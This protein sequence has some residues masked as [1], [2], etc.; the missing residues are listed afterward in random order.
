MEFKPDQT[1]NKLILLFV[2]DKME[3][4]LTENSILD[5][6]TSRNTWINYMECKELMWQL[7]ESG[8][9]Y[10]T[11]GD[12]NEN[13]YNITY[14]GRNCLSHFYKRIPLSLRET[15]TEFTKQNRMSVKR[16]QEYLSD[17]SKNADGSFTMHLKI[18]SSVLNEAMFE[19]K[20]KAP[21]RNSAMN[22]CKIWQE[23]APTVYES[24][25]DTL[26]NE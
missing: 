25:Y 16:S 2:M 19:I 26:I 13:R 15:I 8:F 5:I 4:P 18:R 10:K 21:S 14:E 9:L 7:L 23:N 12:E 22:A 24:I 1:I 11:E 17:Y 3:I 6:C 20:I